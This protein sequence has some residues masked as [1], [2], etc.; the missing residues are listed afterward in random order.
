MFREVCDRRL[1]VKSRD[2]GW[3]PS[4]TSFRPGPP[5]A[6]REPSQVHLAPPP[7]PAPPDAMTAG[8]GAFISNSSSDQKLGLFRDTWACVALHYV[9]LRTW[10]VFKSTYSSRM[11][12]SY[13]IAPRTLSVACRRLYLESLLNGGEDVF[14]TQ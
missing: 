13:V 10:T 1:Y 6:S 3:E 7:R 14:C 2:R 9:T 11:S 4:P 8:R 5:S 12:N